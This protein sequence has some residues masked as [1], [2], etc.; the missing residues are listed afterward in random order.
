MKKNR[1]D[2]KLEPGDI[3]IAG[4]DWRWAIIR[5]DKIYKIQYFSGKQKRI[6]TIDTLIVC[7]FGPDIEFHF[8]NPVIPYY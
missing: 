5:N 7:E 1:W 6:E 3:V 4:I 8:R 2:E